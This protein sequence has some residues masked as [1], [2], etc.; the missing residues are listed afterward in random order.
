MYLVFQAP[1]KDKCCEFKASEGN[2]GHNIF[3]ATK[4][5]K[6][7]LFQA[8]ETVKKFGRFFITIFQTPNIYLSLIADK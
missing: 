7:G 3:P 1:E 5:A 2:K 4:N 6:N 8:P